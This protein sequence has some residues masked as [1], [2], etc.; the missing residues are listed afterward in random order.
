MMMMIYIKYLTMCK[1]HMH[2]GAIRKLLYGCG[3]VQ[4]IIHLLKLVDYLPLHTHKPYNRLTLH[5]YHGL[6][7][8]SMQT[9][10]ALFKK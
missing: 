8:F 4:E 7:M 1:V 9:D 2:A 10:Y 6:T 3:Y 5:M